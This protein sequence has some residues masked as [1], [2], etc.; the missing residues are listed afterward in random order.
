MILG[1]LCTKTYMLTDDQSP[2]HTDLKYLKK[3]TTLFYSLPFRVC[4]WY[5][6]SQPCNFFNFVWRI[7]LSFCFPTQQLND[8]KS[9]HTII[10]CLFPIYVHFPI[11]NSFN[12]LICR[13]EMTIVYV[14]EQAMEWRNSVIYLFSLKCYLFS[15]ST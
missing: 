10:F 5:E 1:Y 9:R 4:N 7:F 14:C 6:R 11:F 13:L 8:V 3:I 12:C 2:S 15:F